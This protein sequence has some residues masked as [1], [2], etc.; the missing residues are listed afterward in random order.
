M[1]ATSQRPHIVLAGGGTAGHLFPGL[2]VARRLTELSPGLRITF[3]GPGKP[4]EQRHVPGA[5]FEY[6]MLPCQPWPQ[7]LHDVLGFLGDNLAGYH[8]AG[9]FLVQESV[10]AVV[11]LGGYTSVPMAR[12]A[13]RQGLPLVLLEQNVIPG[14]ATRW[15]ARSAAMIC[16]AFPETH[17][18]LPAR[19]RVHWTGNPIRE[20]FRR[21]EPQSQQLL[22]LGGSNGARSLNQ[23]VPLALAQIRPALADWRIIHQSGQADVQSTRKLY[24]QL[25]LE[26]I[27]CPFLDDMPNLLSRTG[28]AVCRAGGTTMAELA[29]AGIPA[30][31]IPYPHAVNDHQRLNA[32]VLVAAGAGLLIDERQTTEGLDRRLAVCLSD[33]LANPLKRAAMS[34][35]IGQFAKPQAAQEVALLITDLLAGSADGTL[36]AAA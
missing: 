3:A 36:R 2:A 26:A 32:D 29:A 13:V 5:G 24:R 11:G 18:H 8:A 22:V 17:K 25:G 4:L 23:H 35:A 14:R 10:A 9:R 15:L 7:R 33:L 28:L 20:G 27:V 12:A 1:T 34:R 6:L 19:C 16:T 31:F 30:V 21:A